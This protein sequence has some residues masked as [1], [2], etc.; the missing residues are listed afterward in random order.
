MGS[1]AALEP[2]VSDQPA[3]EGGP[4]ARAPEPGSEALLQVLTTEEFVLQSTRASTISESSGRATIFLGSVSSGLIAI[5]LTAQGTRVGT[6]FY[7]LA[8][9][10]LP[11]LVFL[12]LFSYVRVMQTGIEDLACA[13][14]IARIRHRYATIDPDYA[15][16]LP[17]PTGE[18]KPHVSLEDA[19]SARWQL[20]LTAATMIAT[21]TSVLAGATASLALSAAGTPLVVATIAAIPVGVAAFALFLVDQRTRWIHASARLATPAGPRRPGHPPNR[22]EED[23]G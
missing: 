22:K 18:A 1:T 21:V 15:V 20:L 6:T 4:G 17:R 13:A 8:L 16:V 9:T 23:N 14:A 3:A 10:V 2:R 11:T 19:H 5:A 12:G 7:V